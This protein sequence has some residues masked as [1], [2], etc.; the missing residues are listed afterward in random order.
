MYTNIGLRNHQSVMQNGTKVFA[1]WTE[2]NKMGDHRDDAL[3]SMAESYKAHLD[4]L[5]ALFKTA[6]IIIND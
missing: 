4:V 6:N 5:D 3:R 1:N 2:R